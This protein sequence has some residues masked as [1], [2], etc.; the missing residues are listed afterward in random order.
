MAV[1]DIIPFSLFRGM[2]QDKPKICNDIFTTD[3][4]TTIF[5]LNNY[6]VLIEPEIIINHSSGDIEVQD[7]NYNFGRLNFT[8][9]PPPY[10]VLEIIYPY[11]QLSDE[12]INYCLNNA[13]IQHD[14]TATWDNFPSEYSPYVCW[15]AAATAYYMLASKWATSIHIK[16]ETVDSR[17]DSV[18][19]R[20]FN[21][22]KQME[23][24]YKQASAG[25]IDVRTV[26]RRD[27]GTGLLIPLNEG[28]VA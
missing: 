6:P 24:R 7:I 13:L 25:T 17:E 21:L 26:T 2:I 1:N 16:V 3:G 28:D 19:I 27:V 23:D 4:N 11:A 8:S 12:E 15:L 20:Y 18:A 14:H 9:N 5:Q 10:G 22:A